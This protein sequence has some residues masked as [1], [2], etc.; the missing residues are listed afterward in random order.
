MTAFE[1]FFRL[2]LQK[3][4][5]RVRDF[6]PKR[7]PTFSLV[8]TLRSK[9]AA[10]E[11]EKHVQ[12]IVKILLKEY[13]SLVQEEQLHQNDRLDVDTDDSVALTSDVC[14]SSDSSYQT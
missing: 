10:E 8:H 4:T 5:K 2:L 14:F 13:K 9:K 6:I 1:Q 11:F 12:D 3:V 7:Q